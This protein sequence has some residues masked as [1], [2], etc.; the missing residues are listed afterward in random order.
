MSFP[1]KLP[2]RYEFNGERLEGGQG[3]VYICA[4]TF[5]QRKVAIKVMKLLSDGE[6]LKREIARLSEIRSRHVAEVYDLVMA[7]RSGMLGLVQQYVSGMDL[8]EY[9]KA[10][11][12]DGYLHVLWQIACGL[13]DIHQHRKIHRDIKPA[14]I[15][16]DSERVIK[17]LDFGL[18]AD[19]ADAVTVHA[20]GTKHFLA[21]ELYGSPPIPLTNAIDVYA[22]GVVA[23]FLGTNGKLAAAICQI[24]PASSIPMPSFAA[25]GLPLPAEVVQVLD[26]TLNKIPGMRPGMEEVRTV[27]EQYLLYGRHRA[28]ISYGSQSR[29]L[30]TPGE[31]I[32]LTAGADSLT[33]TLHTTARAFG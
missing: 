31:T 15:R 33:I 3:Y 26:R 4:D 17:I 23:W 8:T 16:F 12:A 1:F 13:S 18:A 11:S 21:P 30:S 27:L 20:R 28:Y 6:V 24:P 29:T 22:F 19:S 25:T 32:T 14:N 9:A 10:A 5:L 2:P 7:K